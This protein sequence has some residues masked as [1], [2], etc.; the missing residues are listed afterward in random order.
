VGSWPTTSA[1]QSH[2]RGTQR[3]TNRPPNVTPALRQL[4]QIVQRNKL[5]LATI[6]TPSLAQ[7]LVLNNFHDNKRPF[8]GWDTMCSG[9][10]KRVG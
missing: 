5:Q 9:L 8:A 2:L 3:E 1:H 6:W 10:W 7:V 4:V